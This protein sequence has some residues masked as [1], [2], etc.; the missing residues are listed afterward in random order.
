M[1]DRPP[2]Q[3]DEKGALDVLRMY[4]EDPT[5]M[6]RSDSAALASMRKQTVRLPFTFSARWFLFCYHVHIFKGGRV[7]RSCAGGGTGGA[8]ET[9][10]RER[11]SHHTSQKAT[12]KKGEG[13]ELNVFCPENKSKQASV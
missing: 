5:T 12:K 9:E 6:L 11:T 10:K 2:P 13:K 7:G 3:V 1:P 4:G 8:A